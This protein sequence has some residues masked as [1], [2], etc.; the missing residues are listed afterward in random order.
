MTLHIE[1]NGD[2]SPREW[3]AL[4]TL[5]IAMGGRD[6]AGHVAAATPKAAAVSPVEGILA[7]AEALEAAAAAP[8]GTV[9]PP[10]VTTPPP[11]PVADAAPAG[12][13]LDAK[14]LPWDGRIHASTKTKTKKGEW[15]Y[16]RKVDPAVVT[17]VEAELRKALNAPAGGVVPPP[18][19][20]P[21]GDAQANIDPAAAFGGALPTPDTVTPP[22]PAAN[23]MA[24]FARVMKVVS[25]KQAAGAVTTEFVAQLCAQLGLTTVRDLATRP[26]MIPAFEALLP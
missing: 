11:P 17:H 20:S 9:P 22:P 8:A 10:P 24:E 25:A 7:K 18:P 19:V 4:A 23:G 6:L 26:D 21:A 12:V 5:A 14:G 1:I 13:E 15:T 16:M 3:S 2:A